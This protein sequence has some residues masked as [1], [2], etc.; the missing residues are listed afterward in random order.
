MTSN[1]VI[2]LRRIRARMNILAERLDGVNIGVKAVSKKMAAAAAWS[3][4][5]DIQRLLKEG[6]FE[7]AEACR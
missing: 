3:M 7:P 1:E 2:E 5:T 6:E 4:A